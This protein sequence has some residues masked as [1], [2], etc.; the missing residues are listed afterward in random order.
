MKH[1]IF[2][3]IY[4]FFI[5]CTSDNEY[6]YFEQFNCDA[7]DIYFFTSDPNK[8]IQAI[9]TSKCLSCHSEKNMNQGAFVILE[10][11]EQ[12]TD[13]S[14]NLYDLLIGSNASMPKEGSQQLTDCEKLKIENWINNQ[15]PYDEMGR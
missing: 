5:T 12:L 8:S 4:I 2:L 14:Y 3:F 15:Y 11:Y 9:I 10:T 13:P 7:N 6:D 1:V